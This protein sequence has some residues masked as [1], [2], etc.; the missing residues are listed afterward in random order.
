MCI[1]DSNN[2][3]KPNN[4]QQY[5]LSGRDSNGCEDTSSIFVTVNA[6][7]NVTITSLNIKCYGV[8]DGEIHLSDEIGQPPF[9][10]S[11][12]NVNFDTF[13]DFINLHPK[14]YTV[15][16]KDSKG[17]MSIPIQTEILQLVQELKTNI[18]LSNPS[19]N[20]YNNGTIIING[21]GG[22]PPLSLIHI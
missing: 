21:S 8:N 11:I 6:L 16:I 3:F 9:Q 20:G 14:V 10:Y 12:D 19:C 4:S 15:S 13:P 2:P 22:N 7:P 1:R 5:F 18:S 17:C